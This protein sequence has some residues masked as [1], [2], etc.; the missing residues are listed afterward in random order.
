MGSFGYEILPVNPNLSDRIFGED[1]YASLSDIEDPVDIVD[2]F[3]RSEEV[4][5]VARE[6]VEIGAKALWLQLGV[7]NEEAAEYAKEHGLTVIMNRCI[8][9][10][11]ASL[12]SR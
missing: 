5:P 9:V 3:R 12:R 7:I 6:A 8:K 4:M 2:V 11:R 10:D 1:P